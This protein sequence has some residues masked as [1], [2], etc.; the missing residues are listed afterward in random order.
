MTRKFAPPPTRF[1]SGDGSVQA[2]AALGQVIHAPPATRFA[3]AQSALQAMASAPC[4]C[5]VP[6]PTRFA[7]SVAVQ[8]KA[9][10]PLWVPPKVVLLAN[11]RG[12]VQ[13]MYDS[14]DESDDDVDD[15]DDGDWEPNPPARPSQP[16]SI[17][18]AVYDE[19]DGVIEGKYVKFPCNS[20]KHHEKCKKRKYMVYLYKKNYFMMSPIGKKNPRLVRPPV[21]HNYPWKKIL[22]KA[23]QLY[24]LDDDLKKFLCWGNLSN[25]TTGYHRCNSADGDS[26]PPGV[27]MSHI[28]AYVRMMKKEYDKVGGNWQID[29]YG[30]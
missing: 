22:D 10:A 30:F 19:D 18:D 29:W 8:P 9:A 6:P 13:R 11:R 16:S 7:A 21:C 12:I 3:P 20:H 4:A 25:L 15:D 26:L 17:F 14:S 27:K 24:N 28:E 23:E 2:K 5:H 1:T